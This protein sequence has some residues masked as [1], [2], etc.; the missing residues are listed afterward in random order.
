VVFQTALLPPPPFCGIPNSLMLFC[1]VTHY[2][3]NYLLDLA[4]GGFTT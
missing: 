3:M 2:T 1:N 4:A